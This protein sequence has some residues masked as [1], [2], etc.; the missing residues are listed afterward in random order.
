MHTRECQHIGIGLDRRHP[1]D[2]DH[3]SK[4]AL[5]SSTWRCRAIDCA[6][7]YLRKAMD[8]D[9]HS[10]LA[11]NRDECLARQTSVAEWREGVL[12]GIDEAGGVGGTWLGVSKAGK[13]GVL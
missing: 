9:G 8:T 12:S 6:L 3:S 4:C 5:L 7:D 1:T 11:S 10:A 2:N 13:V